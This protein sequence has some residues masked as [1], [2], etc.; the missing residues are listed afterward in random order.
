MP[1]TLDAKQRSANASAAS[2]ELVFR[3]T[4][5]QRDGQLIRL[6]SAKCT[7]GSGPHC[8]LRLRAR[9][10]APVHCLLLRGSAATVVRCWSPD[11]R[12]NQQSFTDAPLAIGD[13]LSV[14]PI[15]LEVVGMDIPS[16]GWSERESGRTDRPTTETMAEPPQAAWRGDLDELQRQLD[17]QREQ[18]AA[19][20]ARLA[21]DV[22]EL[23]GERL[24]LAAERSEL[25]TA[26]NAWQEQK[27]L[28]EAK[29]EETQHG[30][31][32]ANERLASGLNELDVQRS[33]MTSQ[34]AVLEREQNALAAER[35]QWRTEQ[36]QHQR[37]LDQE[38]EQLAAEVDRLHAEQDG[39][40]ANRD[41]L[42]E[43]MRCFENER[44]QWESERQ[45]PTTQDMTSQEP[46]AAAETVGAPSE[47]IEFQAASEKA[48]VDLADVF[49]RV[50]AHVDAAD[51]P[52]EPEDSQPN[53]AAANIAAPMK[54]TAQPDNE[55][56]EES[57][58][59][60]MSRHMERVRA[61]GEG[62]APRPTSEE[63][64]PTIGGAADE[65][66]PS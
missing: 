14:G 24:K 18:L 39:L 34:L 19:D 57:L 10:V 23:D 42:L 31:D 61:A 46:P 28:E 15:D 52:S 6:R 59:A 63:P 51:E 9:G 38:R 66:S 5:P 54:P 3:V 40:Q 64:M 44:R 48:P 49:R 53:A 33:S 29:H 7:I 43:E 30:L 12:L 16:D 8:T 50:G 13:C 22:A 32:Q 60:Y 45:Q 25:D 65:Q 55:D 11:T 58:Q 17:Q 47:E 21:A 36:D 56:G 62:A 27:R 26:R 37:Q 35:Q 4:G 2:G 20:A 1:A 41:A